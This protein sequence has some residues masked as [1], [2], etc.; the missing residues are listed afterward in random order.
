MLAWIVFD[1]ERRRE[2]RFPESSRFQGVRPY[3]TGRALPAARDG[4]ER[5][6]ERRFTSKEKCPT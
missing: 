2:W 3:A 1:G 6:V 4:F 5:R